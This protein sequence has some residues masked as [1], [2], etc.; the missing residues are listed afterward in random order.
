MIVSGVIGR[1]IDARGEGMMFEELKKDCGRG[2]LYIQATI[3][4]CLLWTT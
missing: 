2:E 4:H 3:Y 1:L